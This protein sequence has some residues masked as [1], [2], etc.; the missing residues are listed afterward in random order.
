MTPGSSIT[1]KHTLVFIYS[2]RTETFIHMYTKVK[3]GNKNW[4]SIFISKNLKQLFHAKWF[5]LF[6]Y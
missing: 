1:W 6:N 2:F 3:R 4:F 5:F